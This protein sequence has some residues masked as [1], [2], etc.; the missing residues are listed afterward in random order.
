MIIDDSC[1]LNRRSLVKAK[2]IEL[3][4]ETAQFLRRN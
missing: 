3:L 4:N 1:A 2:G